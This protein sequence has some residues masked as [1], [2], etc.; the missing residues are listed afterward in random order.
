VRGGKREGWG[1]VVRVGRSDE[2]WDL[3]GYRG[4]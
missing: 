4:T 1:G 3:L 2:G